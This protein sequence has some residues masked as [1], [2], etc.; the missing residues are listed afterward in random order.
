MK[1]IIVVHQKA[2]VGGGYTYAKAIENGFCKLGYKVL[3]VE[4]Y[5]AFDL[6]RF[7]HKHNAPIFWI[8]YQEMSLLPIIFSKF[9]RR[10][11][12]FLVMNIWVK[13]LGF[14]AE[15]GV[16][17]KLRKNYTKLTYWSKQL[18]FCVFS[19]KIAFLS[20]YSEDVFFS[21]PAYDMLSH[22][23]KKII[24]GGFDPHYFYPATRK[25]VSQL[26]KKYGIEQGAKV[27]LM[28][29]RADS[30]KN[31]DSGL[32][33]VSNLQKKFPNIILLFI[34]SSTSNV[35]DGS[36]LA[37]LFE[38][39]EK[40]GIGEQVRIITGISNHKIGNYYRLA[41]L[42]L[43]MSKKFE[44]FGLVTLEA[45]A[46]GCPV[47]GFASCATTEIIHD[48]QLLASPDSLEDLT[49]KIKKYLLSSGSESSKKRSI[50]NAQAFTWENT[51]A[52]LSKLL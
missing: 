20:K 7:I 40:L 18:L 52:E 48:H 39:I 33:I 27:L 6:I 50:L 32:E 14:N 35:S 10:K 42:F 45:L 51:V 1:K 47:A 25:E 17:K 34:L 11:S 13:E 24:R 5:S 4:G 41:D 29:G 12:I 30:R 37:Y 22:K 38:K 21:I 23:E 3:F 43:M 28:C 31:Y 16:K 2:H 44:T 26:R 49:G 46:C 19:S 15:E 36:Y 9:L 8:V